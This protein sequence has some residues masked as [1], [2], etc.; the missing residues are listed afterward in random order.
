LSRNKARHWKTGC[1]S[2]FSNYEQINLKKINFERRRG[3]G[4]VKLIKCV[5][6]H[7]KGEDITFF[8]MMLLQKYWT[9]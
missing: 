7:R 5:L 6:Q 9:T 8:A 4:F 2:T 3:V 1:G